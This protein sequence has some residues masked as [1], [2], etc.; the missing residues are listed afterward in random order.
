MNPPPFYSDWP[1]LAAFA[2]QLLAQRL[3]AD[4]EAV[5]ANRLS[6]ALAD[7]R[8]RVMGAVV[9][10]WRAIVRR[11]PVPE[12]QAFHAEIRLDLASA[13]AAFSA[14]SAAAPGNTSLAQQLAL[15]V[16]L[17]WNHRGC[18]PGADCPW[19][20]HVHEANLIAR[21]RRPISEAA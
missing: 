18:M 19:I 15:A 5:K 9:A 10:V 1:S 8:A 20:L 13:R 14:R 4:P 3:T 7:D 16:A 17:E 2:E 21:R 12:L 6:Q 11:E